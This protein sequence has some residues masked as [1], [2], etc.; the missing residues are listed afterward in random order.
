MGHRARV[1]LVHWN[2]PARLA[3]TVAAFAAS[4]GVDVAITVVDNDSMPEAVAA[5][6]AVEGIDWV[7]SGGNLGFGPGANVGLHRFLDDADD[8][9]YVVVAPHDA[10]P[11]P[12][13]LGRVLEEL[14]ARPDAGLAC[15]DYGDGATPIIDPYFGG[16][17]GPLTVEEGWEPAGY[18]H[19]TLLVARRSCLQDIGVFDERY[20]SY[21]EEADLGGR[22]RAAGWDVGLVRGA[23]VR[24][25][26]L[27]G[28]L[29][30]VAYLQLRNTL[31][32]VRE[33]SGR[34]HAFVRFQLAALQLGVGLVSPSRRDP[35]WHVAG[36]VRGMLD[37]ARGRFGPPPPDLLVHR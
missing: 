14:D 9:E 13:C 12:D 23:L 15:A 34:Y 10:L 7:P 17:P 27:H 19:G 26:E 28:A 3:A 33:Q 4:E 37:F 30:A 20:F 29:P 6:R 25:P 2:Q 1:V 5:A 36:K 16:I 32:L 11:A 21:C 22:A 24:N 18:P 31:L 35:Y 8:G